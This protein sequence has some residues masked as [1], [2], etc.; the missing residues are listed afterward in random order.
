MIFTF[1]L[2]KGFWESVSINSYHKPIYID[3][4]NCYNKWSNIFRF[5]LQKTVMN[6]FKNIIIQHTILFCETW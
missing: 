6:P 4:S 1:I 5:S 2:Q 3:N